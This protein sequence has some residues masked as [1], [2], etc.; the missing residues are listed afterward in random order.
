MQRAAGK[1]ICYAFS[2]VAWTGVS[3]P[4]SRRR[5]VTAAAANKIMRVDNG[6]IM[7]PVRG[8]PTMIMSDQQARLSG[9]KRGYRALERSVVGDL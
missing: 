2:D 1:Q 6:S 5:W 9:R 3:D 7:R 4:P 8:E